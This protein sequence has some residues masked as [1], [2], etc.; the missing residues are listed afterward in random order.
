M[1]TLTLPRPHAAQQR[2]IDE[3]KRYNVLAC[4]RR[5]GKSTLGEDR[6]IQSALTGLPC[7][8]FSP[9]YKQLADAWRSLQLKLKPLV[10]DVSQQEHRLALKGGGVIECW[11]LDSPD[12]GRGR[13]FAL[14]VVDEAALV[15]DLQRA[16]E[17]GIR[18]M[19]S[20]YKGRAWFLSTPRGVGNYFHTLYQRGQSLLHLG[21]QSWQMPTGANPFISAEEIEAAR[22]DMTEAA[23]SQEYEAAF[24]DTEGAVFRRIQE[25]VLPGPVALRSAIIGV[26]W[27]GTGGR[28]DYTVFT[29]IDRAGQATAIDRFRGQDYAVQRGR[30][31]AFWQRVGR[32]WIIAEANSMGDVLVAQLQ[33]EGLPLVAF[34]TTAL[35]KRV[36]IEHL[37][38]AF[39]RGGIKI[40]ND[41]V[42]I[43]ELQAFASTPLPG[44]GVRY[45][46]PSGGHD[47]T[48]MA[49]AIGYYGLG[50]ARQQRAEQR[51][52]AA[53]ELEW[54]L[55]R[56]RISPY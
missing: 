36:I 11:S 20:D 19:L 1:P 3:A 51:A 16:W 13:A 2:V 46:A 37:A 39:E 5:F 56:V 27:A 10:V 29:A 32:P 6:L 30:L 17:Q 14:A 35:S 40:L 7:A 49:L 33:A 50:A 24:L 48:V 54:E 18:P 9:T 47:D 53:A 23:F 8:W 55:S 22:A 45:G 15:V 52:A 43:G 38:L 21:W 26:D 4:G 12:A 34:Q 41:P 28:G 25:A 42:L 31:V 44:G